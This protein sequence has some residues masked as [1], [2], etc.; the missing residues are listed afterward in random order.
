MSWFTNLAKGLKVLATV[1]TAIV[2]AGK[3]LEKLGEIVASWVPA[4]RNWW[5]GKKIAVLGPTAAGKNSLY[6]RLR[7]QPIPSE[8]AQTRGA[9]K[10]ENF[11]FSF[12]LPDGTKFSISCK[13]ALNVGGERD[14]RNRYWLS[15]CEGADVVF[16][17]LT[18][19]D[20]KGGRYRPGSRGH[21]DLEWL[22]GSLPKMSPKV[23]IHLLVNKSDLVLTNGKT[24]DALSEELR[25]AMNEFEQTARGIF[26]SYQDRLTGVT[27]TSML[28]DHLFAVS[29]G[30]ALQ[31]VHEA[32]AG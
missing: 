2:S 17:M 24:Y 3:A 22:A 26:G 20:L 27:P 8:H 4:A 25:P 10:V 19:D 18:I 29:F 14:E 30:L 5:N 1:V 6:N 23:K 32:S 15:A 9:E 7:G 28:S 16:Y 21:E 11:K 13:G 12:P 31:V